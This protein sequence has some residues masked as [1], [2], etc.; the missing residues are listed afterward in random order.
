ME[1]LLQDLKYAARVLAKERSFTLTSVLT[2]AI[3]IAANVAI[4]AVVNSVLL[5]PLPVPVAQ[6]RREIGIRLALGSEPA[7]SSGSSCARAC[8]WWAWDSPSASPG[9]SRSAVPSRPSCSASARS[10]RSSSAR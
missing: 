8:C 3:C 1:R 4:F 9:R 10:I 2:L 5:E 6:R 7:G